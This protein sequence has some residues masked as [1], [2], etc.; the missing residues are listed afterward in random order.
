LQKVE[1]KEQRNEN[2]FEEIS[3]GVEERR[4]MMKIEEHMLKNCEE[5]NTKVKLQVI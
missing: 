4:K 3:L 1:K 2:E 5:K